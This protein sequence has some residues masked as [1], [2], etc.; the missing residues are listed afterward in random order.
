MLAT[1]AVQFALSSLWSRIPDFP[2]EEVTEGIV[3]GYEEEARA[4]TLIVAEEVVKTFVL[5]TAGDPPAGD[6]ADLEAQPEEAVAG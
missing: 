1:E 3:R 2:V 6:G 5:T 4:R